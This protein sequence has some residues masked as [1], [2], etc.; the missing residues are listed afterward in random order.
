MEKKREKWTRSDIECELEEERGE[1]RKVYQLKNGQKMMAMSTEPLHSWNE[2]SG[3]YE[4]IG[5][6]LSAR[7]SGLCGSRGGCR[8]TLPDGKENPG[9]VKMSCGSRSMEWEYLGLGGCG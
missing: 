6:G 4:E 2:R 3:R 8:I 7:K 9:R 1:N 5:S